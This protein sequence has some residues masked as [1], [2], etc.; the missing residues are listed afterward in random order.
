MTEMNGFE[1]LE[2]LETLE[3]E[4]FSNIELDLSS[5]SPMDW[6]KICLDYA[7]LVLEPASFSILADATPDNLDEKLAAA[8]KNNVVLVSL[9][10]MLRERSLD[11]LAAQAQELEMGYESTSQTSPAEAKEST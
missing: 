4:E 9:T 1:N 7:K 8:F 6:V 3:E 2:T 10:H 11:E 5:I